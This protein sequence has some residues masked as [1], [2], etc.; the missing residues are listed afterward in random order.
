MFE[1]SANET[2]KYLPILIERHRNIFSTGANDAKPF[3]DTFTCSLNG[4][5]MIIISKMLSYSAQRSMNTRCSKFEKVR[6][7]EHYM[8]K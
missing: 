8:N 4:M 6:I 5:C 7:N 3:H 1:M 2:F